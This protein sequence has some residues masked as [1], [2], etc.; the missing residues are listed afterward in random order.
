[1]AR[2]VTT[3]KKHRNR[4][5]VVRHHNFVFRGIAFDVGD[6]F[7]PIELRLPPAKYI[8]LI[9]CRKI[10]YGDIECTWEERLEIHAAIES[11][12]AEERARQKELAEQKRLA[13]EE[14]ETSHPNIKLNHNGGGW[15]DILVDDVIVNEESMRKEAAQKFVEENYS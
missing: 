2:T 9:R 10:G 12:R 6:E 3:V 1:M 8:Q 7:D 4:G 11:E 14:K 13:D 5:L 15:W